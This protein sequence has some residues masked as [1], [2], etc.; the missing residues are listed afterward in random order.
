MVILKGK[1]KAKTGAAVDGKTAAK[2]SGKIGEPPRTKKID[3]RGSLE[4]DHMRVA[5]F[6]LGFCSL[7]EIKFGRNFQTLLI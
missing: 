4:Y 5:P 7:G 3:L 6:Y 2:R 1:P